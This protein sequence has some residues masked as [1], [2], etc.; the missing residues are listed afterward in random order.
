MNNEEKD[1]LI[2]QFMSQFIILNDLYKNLE[3]KLYV[4]VD[5]EEE[6]EKIFKKLEKLKKIKKELIK[7]Y[8]QLI[9]EF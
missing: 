1:N 8:S 4:C 3:S 6:M 5:Q 2:S 9:S 7:I